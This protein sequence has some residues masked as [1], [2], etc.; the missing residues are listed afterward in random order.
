MTW[1]PSPEARMVGESLQGAYAY[2]RGSMTS[3]TSSV[4]QRSPGA[5]T[6]ALASFIRD[7]WSLSSAGMQRA[8]SMSS[9][10][11]RAD[12]SWRRRD[13]HEDGRAID[14]MIGT[15]RAKGAAIADWCIINAANIGLQYLVFDGV[16]W[17]VSTVGAAF[18]PVPTSQ[19]RA[20]WGR[21]VDYHRDHVHIE[22]TSAMAADGDAMRAAL[23]VAAVAPRSPAPPA[24]SPL[25][26]GTPLEPIVVPPPS[27]ATGAIVAVGTLL[28][29]ARVVAA[30][31]RG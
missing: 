21:A 5:G 1:E 16:D 25:A 15:D 27:D 12:G 10:A 13:L 18:E 24:A 23:G 28:A 19:D 31:R 22:L 30:R 4:V 3:P 20:A 7:R 14:A 26:G 2:E 29:L 9:S 6:R 11:Q 17:C 8:A